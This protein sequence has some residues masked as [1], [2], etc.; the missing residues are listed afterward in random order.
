MWEWRETMLYFRTI[1]HRILSLLMTTSTLFFD[2]YNDLCSNHGILIDSSDF[3]DIVEF[4][5][6]LMK[7]FQATQHDNQSFERAFTCLDLL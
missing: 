2:N 7:N 6:D 3:L 1:V 5:P 4:I